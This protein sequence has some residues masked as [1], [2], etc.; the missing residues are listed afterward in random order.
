M[1]GL[2]L[3]DARNR[4]GTRRRAASCTLVDRQ[5]DLL[6]NLVTNLVTN[7]LTNL[8]TNLMTNLVTN[9]MTNLRRLR[10][11]GGGAM[12]MH[13]ALIDLLIRVCGGA[14]LGRGLAA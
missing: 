13:H 5:H 1:R 7:L 2:H 10:R 4:R 3:D 14:E 11:G 12:A 9:L 8:L 6:T